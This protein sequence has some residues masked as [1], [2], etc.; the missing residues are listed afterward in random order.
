MSKINILSSDVYNK[1]S[2]GEV[3]ERPLSVVKELVENSIDASATK[4]DIYA[5][6]GGR[7]ITVFDNGCGIDKDDLQTAFLKHTTSKISVASDLNDI[8]TLGFRGEALSS[9]AS[10]SQVELVSRTKTQDTAYKI[11]LDGGE[12]VNISEISANIGTKITVENLFYNTPARLKFLKKPSR[13]MTEIKSYVEKFILTNPYIEIKY[14]ADGELV[15]QFSG[16]GLEEAIFCVYGK[17]CLKNCIKIDSNF[18]NIKVYGYV[19]SLQYTKSNTNSQICAINGRYVEDSLVSVAVKNAFK[20]YLMTRVFP[21]YVL[22]LYVPTS[23]IDVNVHPNK[24]EVRY[25]QPNNIYIATYMPI[26]NILSEQ[27]KKGSYYLEEAIVDGQKAVIANS[28]CAEQQQYVFCNN[29]DPEVAKKN[30]ERIEAQ[31]LDFAR[32][33][34]EYIKKECVTRRDSETNGLI[35]SSKNINTDYLSQNEPTIIDDNSANDINH[36]D[37]SSY[38]IVNSSV[39]KSDVFA[40]VKIIGIL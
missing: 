18:N 38:A 7:N 2:A 28:K 16:R 4:V 31:R 36:I 14:Y 25:A 23:E 22:N 8:Q 12:T 24:L 11:C 29:T 20:P 19:G 30:Y 39:A 10:V 40:G 35:N 27:S 3:V 37:S 5:S 13:E 34:N 32:Q 21:F 6:F 26:K 17:T 15:Y 1:I 33:F 9:I